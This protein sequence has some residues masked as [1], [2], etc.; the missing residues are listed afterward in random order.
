MT[1][2]LQTISA[3]IKELNAKRIELAEELAKSESVL[4]HFGDKLSYCHQRDWDR[5]IATTR[6][7]L[8][9]VIEDLEFKLAFAETLA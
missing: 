4:S 6:C 3:E 8:E 2:L 9:G 1:K 5:R 7:A